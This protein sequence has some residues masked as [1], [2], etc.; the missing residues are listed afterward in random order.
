MSYMDNYDLVE[1]AEAFAKACHI[2]Q[3]YGEFY[4]SVHLEDVLFVI[5]RYVSGRILMYYEIYCAAWLHDVVEDCHVP[6]SIIEES[7]GFACSVIVQLL[8]DSA[9]VNRKQ[10]KK[11]TYNKIKSAFEFVN[12]D[13]SSSVIIV[14]FADRIA[15]HNMS[16][17]TKNIKKIK[18]YCEEYDDFINVYYRKFA[19]SDINDVIG[20]MM[21][22]LDTQ[23]KHMKKM[24]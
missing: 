4:Y 9:G 2:G 1:K 11:N 8:T 6:L 10:K 18:M 13:I 12:S 22:E 7:F 15:N 23:I 5:D 19:N 24:I 21:D 14:K 3:K 17:N 16:I 20:L